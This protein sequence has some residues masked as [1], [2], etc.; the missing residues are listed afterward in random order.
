MLM[1]RERVVLWSLLVTTACFSEPPT[2]AETSDATTSD[3]ASASAAETADS[4]ETAGAGTDEGTTS[5]GLE[6]GSTSTGS[7]SGATGS[8]SGDSSS[9]RVLPEVL[10]DF[11]DS[12]CVGQWEVSDGVEFVDG[13]CG[14]MPMDTNEAGGAWRFPTLMTMMGEQERVLVLRPPPLDT[15]VVRG[16]FSAADVVPQPGAVL[17]LDYAFVSVMPGSVS[18]GTMTF[19]AYVERPDGATTDIILEEALGDGTMGSLD[20]PLD[21]VVL[22]DLDSIV[23]EVRSDAYV[24]GQGVALRGM[25]VIAET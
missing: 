9:T 11:Y 19:H 2:T 24:E 8:S 13:A 23:L 16:T 20:I 22:G 15:A 17:E 7:R 5:G 18:V 1:D 4:A 14:L 12:A 3:D 6:T 21:T 10:F 25:R